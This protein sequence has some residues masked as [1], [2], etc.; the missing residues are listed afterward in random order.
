MIL[1]VR[2]IANN[3]DGRGLL[4][5]SRAK[6]YAM[7]KSGEFPKPNFRIGSSVGWTR[8]L[9]ESWVQDNRLA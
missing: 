4:N 8:D 6:F 1:R 7:V 2:D 5:V 9:V 3:T